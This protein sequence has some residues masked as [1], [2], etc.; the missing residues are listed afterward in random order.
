[1]E[2]GRMDL[3]ATG[4]YLDEIVLEAGIAR[5]QERVVV[6]DS[7]NIDILIVLPL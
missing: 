7:R 4:K 6:L 3:F 2:D 1:M 5:L